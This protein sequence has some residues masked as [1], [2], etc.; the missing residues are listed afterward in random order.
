[1]KAQEPLFNYSWRFGFIACQVNMV[2][3]TGRGDEC[4]WCGKG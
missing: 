2:D 3:E 4:G 1:M